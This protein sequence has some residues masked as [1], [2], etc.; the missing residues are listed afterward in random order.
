M[1]DTPKRP[2]R[3]ADFNV[4]AYQVFQEAIGEPSPEAGAVSSEGIGPPGVPKDDE[5]SKASGRKGGLK[6]ASNLSPERRSE[7][8]RKAART[9]WGRKPA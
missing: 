3:A 6:R 7:I 9:R 2:K 8:A 1:S 5:Q 4:R